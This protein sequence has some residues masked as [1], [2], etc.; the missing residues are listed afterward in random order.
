MQDA[1]ASGGLCPPDPYRGGDCGPHWGTSIPQTA[2]VLPLLYFSTNPTAS[3]TFNT[4]SNLPLNNL[5]VKW[6]NLNWRISHWYNF[7]EFGFN[8]VLSL[9]HRPWVNCKITN[10]NVY[11]EY[12]I[13][14]D[15]WF[16]MVRVC[17][18]LT[19]IC[20][21]SLI[22]TDCVSLL[23]CS[24]FSPLPIHKVDSLGPEVKYIYTIQL[25]YECVGHVCKVKLVNDSAVIFFLTRNEYLLNCFFC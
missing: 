14:W 15:L 10:I 8:S 5:H 13:A 4:W 18:N 1:S 2:W 11:R 6:N 7:S 24:S 12:Y 21:W 19:V 25:H 9:H 20:S 23:F 17:V 16:C 22:V 3:Y